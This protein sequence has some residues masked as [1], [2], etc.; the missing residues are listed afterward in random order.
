MRY[1]STPVYMNTEVVCLNVCTGE[2]LCNQVSLLMM[3][4]YR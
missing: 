1:L 2:H 4:K 3:S